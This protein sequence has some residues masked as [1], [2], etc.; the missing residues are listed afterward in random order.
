MYFNSTDFFGFMV[1]QF[2]KLSI[3][4]VFQV[5][6]GQESILWTLATVQTLL[7]IC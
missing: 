4:I 3:H 2:V 5:Y 7:C 1:F 6:Y